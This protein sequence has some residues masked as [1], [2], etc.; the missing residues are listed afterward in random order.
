MQS[1]AVGEMVS[2]AVLEL[3][4]AAGSDGVE[5]TI[6]VPR[7]Q[8][9]GLALTGYAEQLHPGRLLVLGGTE[10]SYLSQIEISAQA[11]AVG[12]VMTAEPACLVLTRGLEPMA[13]LVDACD[14]AGVPLLVTPLESSE[15]I[16]RV[17]AYLDVQLAPTASLHGVM[18]D[19]LEVGILLLGKS[20][21][22]KSEAALELVERG[23]RLIADDVVEV[24]LRA[25]GSLVTRSSRE[26]G[27]HMEIRGLGIINIA[28]LFG[29][30]AIRDSK[31]LDLVMELSVWDDSEA[32]D[33]LG[34]D[35][36]SYEIL[37]AQVPFLR[38]PVR[39]GRNIASI[40]EVAARNQL[41]KEL[42]H[43]S[44][45]EFLQRLDE[46]TSRARAQVSE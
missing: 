38:V 17:K 28:D 25:D 33:R 7:I 11:A 20:G 6:D 41:L 42:G 9:P 12:A 16:G 2:E 39:P 18:V 44:A 4:V 29:I 22:G 32:Y 5:R 43:Y 3:S 23:H 27:H 35:D 30:T 15:F 46:R 31:R 37:S 40:I 8:K 24:Q 10:H 36:Q 21:V 45:R 34:V 13:T 14:R 19:V 26:L 1:V